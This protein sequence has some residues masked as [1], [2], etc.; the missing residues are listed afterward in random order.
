VST[1]G[2]PAISVIGVKSVAKSS[3]RLTELTLRGIFHA[4]SRIS[5]TASLNGG[6]RKTRFDGG[7]YFPSKLEYWVLR[8]RHRGHARCI[9]ER[10]MLGMNAVDEE[11]RRGLGLSV[12]EV[13][14]FLRAGGDAAE[15]KY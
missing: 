13:E 5:M 4:E 2:T 9:E 3:P 7:R 11:L 15:I 12:K 8:I 14:P 1:N 10:T 6:P